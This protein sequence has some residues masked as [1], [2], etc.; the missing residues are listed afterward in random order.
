M[1]SRDR[2]F[3]ELQS[4]IEAFLFDSRVA[5]VFEDMIRRSV[6][7]YATAVAMTGVIAAEYAQDA[8]N[9]YDLGCSLGATTAAIRQYQRARDCTIIA[10]DNSRSMI[11][12]CSETL[13]GAA[14]EGVQLLC[15]DIRAIEISNASVVVLNFTLQF[16]PVGERL[17]LLQKIHDGLLPGGI[18]I[19]SEKLAFDPGQ[20][21]LFSDL[22]D[23]FKQA[24]GY[25]DLEISQKRTALEKVLVPE[26]LEQHRRRLLQAGF[27]A[28]YCWFQCLNF[29]SLIALKPGL[30]PDVAD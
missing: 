14:A 22:H 26:T 23:S 11:D 15:D 20:Q 28:V 7:G 4:D 2:L 1:S 24:N 13:D 30:K 17:E 16:I 25:S 3:A 9:I 5:A 6:P 10:V 8:T 21:Q 27:S 12:S 29:A 19:L 18:L